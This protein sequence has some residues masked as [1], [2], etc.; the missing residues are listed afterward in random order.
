MIDHSE[1]YVE[2]HIHTNGIENFWSLFKRVIY[3]THHSVEPVHLDR[4]LAEN[5]LRFNTRRQG[6]DVRFTSTA[7]RVVGR[8]ITYRQLT[9]KEPM[10]A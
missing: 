7:A 2:G 5:V 4:Y 3:G 10:P 1:R 9:G 8:R 6:D